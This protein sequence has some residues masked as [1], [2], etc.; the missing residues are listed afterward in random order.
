MG[1]LRVEIAVLVAVEIPKV[2]PA[3]EKAF[4]PPWYCVSVQKQQHSSVWPLKLAK[5]AVHNCLS[6]LPSANQK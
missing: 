4:R 2:E 3:A 5:L 6:I 1:C